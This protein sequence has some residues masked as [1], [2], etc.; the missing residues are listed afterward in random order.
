M[1]PPPLFGVNVDPTTTELDESFR[2]AQLADEKG[3]DLVLVQDHPYNRRF[4]DTV[5]LLMALAGRTERVQ[6]GTNVVNLPL[7]PPSMLAKQFAT[8]DV[9]S[10]GRALL[11]LGAGAFWDPVYAM[12]GPKRTPGEAYRAFDDALHIVR[13]LWD[14]AGHGFTYEGEFYQ[15]RGAQFGPQPA[16]RIPIWAGALGPKMLRLTG[17]MADGLLVS[18]SY[19]PKAQLASVNATID[20]GA[21]E[22]GRS[23][24]S[25]RRGYNLMGVIDAKWRGGTP[26]GLQPGVIYG[27][28][29][30][31]IAE[32]VSLYHEHRIDT[33]TFWPAGENGAEQIAI[34][35]D[36]IAPAVREQ[37]SSS[38]AVK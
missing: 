28:A 30:D 27:N 32:L 23:P 26:S 35:A 20:E 2:R 12:G 34:F 8:L 22:A 7:R 11:G 33:F 10:G 19:V 21:A 24:E 38:T 25:I 29:N 15:V 5:M 37:V 4:V 14:N 9:L 3:I 16:H 18:S 6:L 17:K 31:W 36:E 13:G 1:T